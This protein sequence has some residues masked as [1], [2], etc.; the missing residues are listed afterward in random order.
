METAAMEATLLRRDACR[1]HGDMGEEKPAERIEHLEPLI[2][3]VRDR[4]V[5]LDADLARL[6]GVTTRRFNE[7][8]RRNRDRF[9]DDFAFQL[10]GDE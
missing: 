8:F 9:P 1:V 5:I 7:G 10:T 4:R 2:F 6:Y 3:T